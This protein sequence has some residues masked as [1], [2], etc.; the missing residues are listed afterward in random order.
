[1]ADH[2]GELVNGH[3]AAHFRIN[4]KCLNCNRLDTSSY[5]SW[6]V[7]TGERV[8]NPEMPGL[9]ARGAIEPEV[10]PQ[11]D[12]VTPLEPSAHVTWSTTHRGVGIQITGP[13]ARNNSG[14]GES[15]RS[16]APL[17]ETGT[18]FIEVQYQR[19][20]LAVGESLMSCY[21]TGVMSAEAAR[22]RRTFEVR[23]GLSRIHGFWGVDDSG[24]AGEGSG[25]RLGQGGN[26]EVP[27]AARSGRGRVFRNGDRVGLLVDMDARRLTMFLNG[28]PIPGLVFGGLPDRVYVCATPFNDDATATICPSR[29]A[30][31]VTSAPEEVLTEPVLP[32]PL[33]RSPAVQQPPSAGTRDDQAALNRLVRGMGFDELEASRALDRAHGRV[34][35]AVDLLL[36]QQQAPTAVYR[37]L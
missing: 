7:W 19:G 3:S 4:N 17:P 24:G 5:E 32:P 20:S 25:M 30:P 21:F 9:V 35:F 6:P 18:H 15:L 33:A 22:D 28:R 31:A 14:R 12:E 26:A 23:N 13:E 11:E 8:F 16:A 27:A 37:S 36:A 1:M 2:D 34:D 10:V 29:S